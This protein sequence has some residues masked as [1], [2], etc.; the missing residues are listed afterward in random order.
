M[1][2]TAFPA[3]SQ[4]L[5]MQMLHHVEAISEHDCQMTPMQPLQMCWILQQSFVDKSLIYTLWQGCE[6]WCEFFHIFVWR[7]L[8]ERMFAS[9]CISV[10]LCCLVRQGLLLPLPTTSLLPYSHYAATVPVSGCYL[11]CCAC[12]A[13]V[14]V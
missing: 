2:I 13:G 12:W 10:C 6:R 3:T 5:S 4:A 8:V 7:G 9:V 1:F 14:R 11:V